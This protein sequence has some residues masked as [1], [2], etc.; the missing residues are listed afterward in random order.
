MEGV[1][2]IMDTENEELENDGAAGRSEGG[3]NEPTME[4]WF[5]QQ[6]DLSKK[7]SEKKVVWVKVIQVA[8]DHVL[9][10]IG[11]K[12]EGNIPISE[13]VKPPALGERIPILAIGPRRSGSGWLSH[14]S[15]R[16][17]LSWDSIVKSYQ[18]KSRVRGRVQSAVRGGFLVDV[19]GAVGFLPQSLADIYP[20]H[21]PDRLLKTGVRCYIIELDEKKKRFVLSRKAVLIEE[22]AKR[23]EELLSKIKI[24][25]VRI[26]RV[27][28]VQE[29]GLTIDIGGIEGFARLSDLAWGKPQAPSQKKGDKL[30][31]KVI[32]LPV[33]DAAAPERDV[34]LLGVKQLVS[35]PADAIKRKHPPKTVV[36]GPVA[37]VT[38]RGV[39]I[40][41][42]ARQK[43]FCALAEFEGSVPKVGET[44][45]AIVQGVDEGT[46]DLVVSVAKFAQ[47]EDRKKIAQYLKPPKPLTL[48]Q[49]LSADSE[50][51]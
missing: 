45:S 9:V 3:S 42:D 16:Q 7:L 46:F 5:S 44:I 4:S 29:K 50:D 35:N 12:N 26:G 19:G 41:V 24:G 48:G 1:L 8:P 32:G 28:R 15:A 34:L 27:A 23:Q 47:I 22:K 51:Q 18:E 30:K 49:L 2:A 37:E 13:F 43:A 36:K 11:E 31:V 21:T 10:D 17:A 40:S 6:E 14:L 39:R 38:E 33:K 25:D 20:V